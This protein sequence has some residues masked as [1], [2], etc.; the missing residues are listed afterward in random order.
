MSARP[1]LFALLLLLAPVGARASVMVRATLEELATEATLVVRGTV[2]STEGRLSGDGRKIYTR[3]IVE[4]AQAYKGAAAGPLIVHAPGGSFAGRGQLVHGAPRFDRGDELVL[5]LQKKAESPEGT[6][7]GVVAMSQGLLAVT[8]DATGVL[9]VAPEL[10]GL[11][12][13]EPDTKT[14]AARP[15]AVPLEA[16]EA[17]LRAALAAK[18]SD[19]VSAPG[20]VTK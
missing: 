17:R 14:P 19:E 16:F 11:E 15:V 6:I 10:D 18:V 13:V 3:A 9:L 12:L 5:F 2:T 20:A 1:L 8:T 4:V 7:W